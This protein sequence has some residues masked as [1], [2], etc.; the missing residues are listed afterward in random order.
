[1]ALPLAWVS[2]G[3]GRAVGLKSGTAFFL[4]LMPIGVG[5][6]PH[7][8]PDQGSLLLFEDLPR[9]RVIQYIATEVNRL[10]PMQILVQLRGRLDIVS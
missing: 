4:K 6:C 8:P 1:M 2:L 10:E 5:C 7:Q 3:D 9:I